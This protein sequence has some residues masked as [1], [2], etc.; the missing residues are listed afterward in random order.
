MNVGRFDEKRVEPVKAGVEE[1]AFPVRGVATAVVLLLAKEGSFRNVDIKAAVVGE[2]AAGVAVDR[3]VDDVPE[4][5]V[6]DDPAAAEPDKAEEVAVGKPVGRVDF[7]FL[8]SQ[9]SCSERLL[10]VMRPW[11]RNSRPSDCRP[12]WGLETKSSTVL[13]TKACMQVCKGVYMVSGR[14]NKREK[15]IGCRVSIRLLTFGGL[16]GACCR[17]LLLFEFRFWRLHLPHSDMR[18]VVRLQACNCS[19]P[20]SGA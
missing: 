4:G 13:L 15:G 19:F 8:K 5:R 18:V 16:R 6:E 1:A 11:S 2:C 20:A 17:P 12:T 9:G 14:A 7:G 3:A 10:S